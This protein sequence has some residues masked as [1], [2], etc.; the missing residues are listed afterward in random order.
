MN[1]LKRI[2]EFLRLRW[3]PGIVVLG[4]LGLLGW[5]LFARSL[6]Y[7]RAPG[8]SFDEILTAM[9][10]V[11]T[12]IVVTTFSAVFVALTLASAQF[13]PRIVRGFFH[14][15]WR[16]Q[17][18]LILFVLDIAYCFVIKF[19][20]LTQLNS[21]FE[22]LG[23]QINFAELGIGFGVV[24]ILVVFPYFVYY[25][26]RNINAA[27][28]TKNIATRTIHEIKVHF[29]DRWSL[30]DKETIPTSEPKTDEHF[31]P[32]P[33]MDSGYLDHY[34][35]PSLRL[36]R[37]LGHKVHINR[38]VG[39]FVSKGS[40]VGYVEYSGK[41]AF[42]KRLL[43]WLIQSSIALREYR[44]YTQDVNFGIRQLVDIAIKAISP[45]VNDPTTAIT[46]INYL[47]E[48][49]KEF[50]GCRLPSR[51][52]VRLE[53]GG[54][55]VNEFN[56]E[57]VVDQA[58]NQIHQ[59]GRTDHVIVR[60]IVHVVTEIIQA[61]ENP[62]NLLILVK[63]IE[64]MELLEKSPLE[65]KEIFLFNEYVASLRRN[66]LYRF[67]KSSLRAIDRIAHRIDSLPEN[68]RA[69]CMA[70]HAESLAEMA[71]VKQRLA[72]YLPEYTS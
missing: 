11:L 45:A 20:G 40:I 4:T 24:L 31:M 72:A 56:F 9:A 29:R 62:H 57:K 25:L 51:L 2:A 55:H 22:I 5:A 27:K 52:T 17:L 36:V 23:F 60:H 71:A 58:F 68:Q 6:A 14:E 10:G 48:I 13:S 35:T 30:L 50:S 70:I 46:C 32:I 67:L 47:G 63:E 43:S 12:S 26:I 7:E 18:V 64:D 54:I 41:N 53:E 61:N 66:Y 16:V 1:F 34:N 8:F 19:L 3:V 21:V 39:S 28:I 44:S 49:V 69:A 59:W 65:M 33:A 42:R 15:D 38:F 37:L